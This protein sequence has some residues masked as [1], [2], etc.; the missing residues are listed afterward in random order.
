MD[1]NGTIQ[2]SVRLRDSDEFK[3]YARKEITRPASEAK[4]AIFLSQ[5]IFAARYEVFLMKEK[6]NSK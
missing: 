3:K 1:Q 2:L 6:G 5:K 4:C